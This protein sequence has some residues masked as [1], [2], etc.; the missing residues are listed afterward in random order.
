VWRSLCTGGCTTTAYVGLEYR[1]SGDGVSNSKVIKVDPAPFPAYLHADA[2]S[3]TARTMGVVLL[4][5]GG[6]AMVLGMVVLAL[7]G[8]SHCENESIGGTPRE[9]IAIG[10]P[11]LVGGAGLVAGSI[12]LILANRTKLTLTNSQ[13]G[14]VPRFDLGRG[15][16]MGL[17]GLRF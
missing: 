9:A 13:Y 16:A 6:A 14:S 12:V 17:E 5:V 11:L 15:F 3:S 4:P 8:C 7:S 2:G 1:V 10:V